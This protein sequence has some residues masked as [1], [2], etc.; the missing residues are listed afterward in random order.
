MSDKK[1]KKAISRRKLL[2][3]LAAGGGAVIAG[4]SLPESWSRP[5]VDSVMLPAHAITSLDSFTGQGIETGSIDPDSRVARLLNGMVNEAKAGPRPIP[6][7]VYDAVDICIKSD[8]PGTVSVDAIL[9]GG[10]GDVD[11]SASNVPVGEF[12]PS[13]LSDIFCGP[14]GM[15]STMLDKL[16]LIPDAKALEMALHE[17]QVFSINGYAVGQFVIYGDTNIPFKLPQGDCTPPSCP[18]GP[19]PV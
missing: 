12:P 3:G 10:H 19:V 8:G 16:G 15:T 6:I 2:K 7:V 1:D 9:T 18:P 5:V 4:K 13:P 17:V 11:V 14:Y